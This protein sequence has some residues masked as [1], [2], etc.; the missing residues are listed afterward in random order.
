MFHNIQDQRHHVSDVFAGLL[1]GSILALLFSRNIIPPSWNILQ[2]ENKSF[3]LLHH[4]CL[5]HGRC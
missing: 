2:V 1:I 4:L 5:A 3:V